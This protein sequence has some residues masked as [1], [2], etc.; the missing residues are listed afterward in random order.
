MRRALVALGTLWALSSSTRTYALDPTHLLSEYTFRSWSRRDGLPSVTVQGLAQT[1]DG[2]LWVATLEGLVRFDG[3]RFTTFDRAS[4]SAIPRNDLQTL[5]VGRDG[6]LW[7]ASYGG[8]LVRYRDREFVNLGL[9]PSR[10]SPTITA[11]A[12]DPGGALW[13]GTEAGLLS[14]NDGPNHLARPDGK[15]FEE[16]IYDLAVD[17]EGVLW[18]ATAR[19]VFRLRGSRLEP[20]LMPPGGQ[21]ALALQAEEAGGLWIGTSGGLVHLTQGKAV[22]AWSTEVPVKAVLADRHGGIW[23]GAGDRIGRL[24][25]GRVEWASGSEGLSPGSVTALLQDQEGSLWVGTTGGL[26]QV[27]HGPAVTWGKRQ[28]L[29]DPEVLAIAPSASHPGHLLVGTARGRLARFDGRTFRSYGGTLPFAGRRVLALLEEKGGRLWVG[30]D[31]GLF[32]FARGKWRT[33]SDGTPLPSDPVRSLLRDR[34]GLLWVGTDGG[35]LVAL[36]PK[37]GKTYRRGDGLPSDQ[38]RGLLEKRDGTL[39]VATYGGVAEVRFGGAKAEVVPT[40]GL[41][42]LMGRALFE[43]ED[44]VLW[45]GTYGEGLK[46][47]ANGRVASL[48]SRDGLLSDV[49]Y[50]IVDDGARLWMS[51]NRGIFAVAK[52]EIAS[53]LRG[54]VARVTSEAYGREDGMVTEECGGGFPAAHRDRAGRFW[55]PTGEGLVSFDPALRTAGRT[56]A[57]PVF[58][59]ASVGGRPVPLESGLRVPPGS[60]RLEVRYTSVSFSAADRTLFSY[61]LAGLEGEWN[62]A[63]RRRFATYTNLPPGRYAFEVRARSEGGDW[64]RAERPLDLVVEAHW[65]ETRAAH[66]ALAIGLPLLLGGAYR[67]RM[68]GLAHREREL[69]AR[70]E[71]AVARVKVLRGLLPICAGCKK[72]REGEGYWRQLEA[73]IRDNTEAE[74]SHGICPECVGEWFPDHGKDQVEANPQSD[75]A[76]QKLAVQSSLSPGELEPRD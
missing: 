11:L 3:A 72:I 64:R 76:A 26:T 29:D 60:S 13:L 6:S 33:E 73:Y 31:V 51:C 7:I 41:S 19:G 59:E 38:V 15:L 2:Y 36:G 53:F 30:T 46:R 65:Y 10:G 5:H 42:N 44:G 39:V 24:Q 25:S 70:V 20:V 62:D 68:R 21:T 63:D 47:V 69:K 35:G 9:P 50:A 49:I 61:R 27:K 75:Q 12:S 74:F 32:A 37:G 34:N 52:A 40:A 8:G 23:I 66:L 17:A 22:M 4:V 18:V 14:L 1:P 57:T 16:G 45:V 55:F 28:G 54:E 67:L 43:D 71:E 58:E 48:T 56:A